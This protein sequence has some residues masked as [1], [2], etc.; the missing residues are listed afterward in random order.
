MGHRPSTVGG[1]TG[2]RRGSRSPREIACHFSDPAALRRERA[3]LATH[4]IDSLAHPRHPLEQERKAW[5]QTRAAL[6]TFQPGSGRCCTRLYLGNEFCPFLAWT[7]R[8][9]LDAAALARDR[10]FDVTLVLGPV[11]D[12]AWPATLELLEAARAALGSVEVVANDWGTLAVAAQAG[13]R[14]VAGR[15]LVRMKRLPRVNRRTRPQFQGGDPLAARAP[16]ALLAAQLEQYSQ[17]PWDAPWALALASSLGLC[18]A[19]SDLVP[20]GIR[21]PAD[22]GLPVSLHS[23]F[24]YVTGGGHCPA[25]RIRRTANGE[26]CGRACRRTWIEL[27]YPTPTLPL[28]QIGHTVFAMLGKLIAPCAATERIDRIVVTRGLAM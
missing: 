10:G 6:E 28:V 23:P 11:R 7:R 9:T 22:S 16:E 25:A 27:H 18:R 17:F 2:Q 12:L 21:F 13:H 1:I 19:E 3:F 24:A 20:Q 15:F 8:E 26:V 14:P 4:D 5:D